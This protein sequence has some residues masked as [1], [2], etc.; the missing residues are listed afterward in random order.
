M[1]GARTF[2]TCRMAARSSPQPLAIPHRPVTIDLVIPSPSVGTRSW[3]APIL[4]IRERRIRGSVY[5]YDLSSGIAL[6][7]ATL[8]NPAPADADQFGWSVSVSGD[9]IVVG[10]YLDDTGATNA[11]ARTYTTCP[12][13]IRS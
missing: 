8:D 2:T 5:V 3:S 13:V 7:T 1:R 6:L 11:G 9:T 4:T 12:A 10:A